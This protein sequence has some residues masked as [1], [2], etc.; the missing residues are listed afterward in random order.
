MIN[1]SSIFQGFNLDGPGGCLVSGGVDS[2][3]LLELLSRYFSA[4]K[5]SVTIIHFHFHLRGKESDRDEKFVRTETSR[6]GFPFLSFSSPIEK[7]KGGIQEK[8]REIRRE[9]T[10]RLAR[11]KGWQWIM[12]AHQANDQAETVLM[13][14]LRGAG[15]RGL[16]G[17][18]PVTLLTP[19][20]KLI[21]PLLEIPR[22]RIEEFAVQQ[23][24]SYVQDSSNA[25][26]DYCRNR[27]R[28][29]LL[30][31]VLNQHPAFLDDISVMTKVL[32]GENRIYESMGNDLLQKE[33]GMVTLDDY[34]LLPEPARFFVIEKG[35]KKGGFKKQVLSSHFEEIEGLLK[36]KKDLRRLFGDCLFEKRRSHFSFLIPP[37]FDSTW[38]AP[39]D[40]PGLYS[41]SPLNKKLMIQEK[42]FEKGS[43]LFV[44]PQQ[45]HDSLIV[46][47]PRP[48][49]R[50]IPFGMQGTKKLSDFFTDQKIPRFERH[51]IPVI[52][53][54]SESRGEEIVCLVGHQID[55]KFRVT[56]YSAPA[57]EVSLI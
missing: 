20:L 39:L 28:H 30:P 8:A 50:F 40:G 6:R 24:I 19:D 52:V 42:R 29:Y 12:T 3:V 22:F 53:Q 18:E 9:T 51:S 35:L 4:E 2:M 56:D 57:L 38:Q 11:E 16:K 44:N 17:M 55:H 54:Q 43:R 46:R 13:N 26:D 47:F 36:K 37:P 41:I 33:S 5:N 32:A 14:L 34:F 31:F 10:I 15:L 1:Y 25:S 45:L 7:R 49:D 23:K 27:V 48:G 21:R